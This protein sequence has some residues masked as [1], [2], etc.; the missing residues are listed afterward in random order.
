V[1]KPRHEPLLTASAIVY[2]VAAVGLLF[3]PE[4]ILD[5]VGAS[6]SRFDQT[7]LQLVAAALFGFFMLNWMNRG[8][9][10]G[11]IYGRPVVVANFAHAAIATAMLVRVVPGSP[12]R[13]PAW[14]V[15][16]VYALLAV[17]FG[18]KLFHKPRGN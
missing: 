3:A 10:I 12:A 17:A 5:R 11:G 16:A 9:R 14:G 4:E 1:T 7:L 6:S 13:G 8:S 18:W 2:L 15:L